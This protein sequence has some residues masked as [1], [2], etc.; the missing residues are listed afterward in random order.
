MNSGATVLLVADD[1]D[2]AEAMI[3]VLVDEGY[4]VA[5]ACNGREALDLLHRHLDPSVILL[6]LWMPEMD[7]AEFRAQQLREPD[8]ASIPVVV[9]SADRKAAETARD[10]GASDFAMKPLAPDQLVSLV[11]HNTDPARA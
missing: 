10:L 5:H 4:L 6:D 1:M 9:L 3:D 8:I 7:G 2:I 11:A